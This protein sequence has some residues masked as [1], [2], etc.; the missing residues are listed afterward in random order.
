MTPTKFDKRCKGMIKQKR[1]NKNDNGS[2]K[3]NITNLWVNYFHTY[4]TNFNYKSNHD[5]CLDLKRKENILDFWG[6]WNSK[7]DS[8]R[9]IHINLLVDQLHSKSLRYQLL[10]PVILMFKESCNLIGWE[11]HLATLNQKW[12]LQ[13]FIQKTEILI[14]SFQISMQ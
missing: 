9:F 13:I 7:R 4:E 11:A 3:A 12:Y 10:L 8:F 1:K 14:D 5:S 2:T 6:Y